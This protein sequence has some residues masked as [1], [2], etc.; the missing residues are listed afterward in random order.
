LVSHAE[1]GTQG[2]GENRV[3]RKIFGN[4]KGEVAGEPRRLYN[5]ELY[6]LCSHQILFR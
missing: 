6:D 5:S 3:L 4:K 1:G 2:E